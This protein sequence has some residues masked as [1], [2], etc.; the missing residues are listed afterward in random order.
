M[1]DNVVGLG[2]EPAAL[3]QADELLSL[4]PDYQVLQTLKRR[5]LITAEDLT[6]KDDSP[7]YLSAGIS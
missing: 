6:L 4:K 7:E 3:N 1:C 2:V 5:F